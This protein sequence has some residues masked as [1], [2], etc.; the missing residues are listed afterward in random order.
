MQP[1]RK[2]VTNRAR[3]RTRTPPRRYTLHTRYTPRAP[4]RMLVDNRDTTTT[5][6]TT[7]RVA[8]RDLELLRDLKPQDRLT[9]GDRFRASVR[10]LANNEKETHPI[11]ADLQRVEEMAHVDG[12]S[13]EAHL[14]NML[15]VLF[16]KWARSPASEEPTYERV[17]DALERALDHEIEQEPLVQ[18]VEP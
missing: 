18:E 16:H 4:L 10:A 11:S 14:L 9:D 15:A 7:M 13:R 3:T 17:R 5:E 6:K 12:Y 8:K 2:V 1:S